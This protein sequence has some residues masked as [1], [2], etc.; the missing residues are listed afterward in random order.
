MTI[1]QSRKSARRVRWLS[2]G[3]GRARPDSRQPPQIV[4]QLM[5]FDAIRRAFASRFTIAQ[6]VGPARSRSTG[7]PAALKSP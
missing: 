2:I 5:E 6:F 4:G 7:S 3:Y 1:P